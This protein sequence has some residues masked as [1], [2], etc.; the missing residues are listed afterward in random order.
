MVMAES[1]QPLP[2]RLLTPKEAARFLS[3]SIRALDR[4]VK[5]GV[6]AVVRLGGARRFKLE[7]LMATIERNRS[8]GDG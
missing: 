3:I 8:G 4:L 1:T 7:D 6:V 2:T 5:Q